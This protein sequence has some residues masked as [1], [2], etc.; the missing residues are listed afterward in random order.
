MENVI[1]ADQLTTQ[2]HYVE[3]VV[4][5]QLTR[6]YWE[7][8]RVMAVYHPDQTPGL[9]FFRLK[10]GDEFKIPNSFPVTLSKAN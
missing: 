6:N 7:P 4:T 2:G 1:R 3:R 5:P 9:T 8:Q 10:N